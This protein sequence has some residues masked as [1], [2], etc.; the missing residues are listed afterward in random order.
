M[1]QCTIFNWYCIYL[2]CVYVHIGLELW[3]TCH[4]QRTTMRVG[5]LLLP[6]GAWEPNSGWTEVIKLNSKYLFLLTHLIHTESTHIF[7]SVSYCIYVKIIKFSMHQPIKNNS[8]KSSETFFV[9][10]ASAETPSGQSLFVNHINDWQ[11]MYYAIKT[12]DFFCFVFSIP[13]HY[14]T[15]KWD[16][17]ALWKGFKTIS[18]ETSCLHYTGREFLICGYFQFHLVLRKI[19]CWNVTFKNI[20]SVWKV[21]YLCLLYVTQWAFSRCNVLTELNWLKKN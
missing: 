6:Y 14:Y 18:L 2:M 8:S 11:V 21:S 16:H 3:N 15:G 19:S 7:W 5:S 20:N 12:T 9:I 1:S 13:V 4:I 17:K 10:L